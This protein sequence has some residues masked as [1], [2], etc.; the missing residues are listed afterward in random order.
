MSLD[1]QFTFPF[2][3]YEAD[4]SPVCERLVR[5][6]PVVRVR[7]PDGDTAWLVTGYEEAKQALSDPRLN[8]LEVSTP[9]SRRLES[10]EVGPFEVDLMEVVQGTS[11]R[12]RIAQSLTPKAAETYERRLEPRIADL[13]DA[14]VAAGPPAELLH[15]LYAPITAEFVSEWLGVD[16]A[17][18]R[19][20]H[21]QAHVAIN[22][23]THSD[24]E[25]DSVFAT[26]DAFFQDLIASKRSTPDGRLFSD[27]VAD[28]DAEGSFSD[29]EMAK[30][31]F[32]LL[33]NGYDT[34]LNAVVLLTIRLFAEP[35]AFGHLRQN[36]DE[37]PD[38]LEEMMRRTPLGP[39][40]V[41]VQRVA[42]EDV[43]LHEKLIRPG[44]LVLIATDVANR[45]PRVFAP[46]CPARNPDQ[47]QLWFGHGR[48]SCPGRAIARMLLEMVLHHLLR[49]I[50]AIEPAK[51]LDSLPWR[52][53]LLLRGVGELPVTW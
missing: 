45:D 38:V 37:L 40:G 48:L 13:I 3:D 26:A 44:E 32:S 11:L 41:T 22:F 51:P 18:A 46:S 15:G 43:V 49:R 31:G 19:R 23:D 17:D 29:E 27:L 14:L 28:N 9:G 1:D 21:D 50:P 8:L 24:D 47:A 20:L 52:R 35:S 12:K 10:T 7:R 42:T 36:P 2:G 33:T 30:L 16:P 4:L 34:P 39:S 5:E 53:G 25:L 6:E